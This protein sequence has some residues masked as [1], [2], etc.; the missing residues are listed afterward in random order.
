MKKLL[1]LLL[2][3]IFL[4]AQ[5]PPPAP[6]PAQQSTSAQEDFGHTQ[7]NIIGAQSHSFGGGSI[8]KPNPMLTSASFAMIQNATYEGGWRY[9]TGLGFSKINFGKGFGVN[10]VLTFDLTQQSYSVYYRRRDWYYHVNFG[11]MG[12]ALNRGASITK[13]WE[14]KHF[15]VGAQLGTSVVSN[16]P[17]DTANK[18]AYYAAIPYAVLMIDKEFKVN[19]KLDWKPE[20]FITLCSP[21]YDLGKNFFSTSSTVNIVAGNNIGLKIGKHFKINVDWRANINTTPKFAIMN[22]ILFGSNLKF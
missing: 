22:N 21:Y 15:S 1:L 2:L 3:P 17:S 19:K 8:I 10:A 11:I 4:Y 20:A 14:L 6:A 7:N 18:S 12:I 5:T 16:G 9:G 13:T